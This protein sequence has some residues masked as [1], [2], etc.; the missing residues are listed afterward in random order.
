MQPDQ[1]LDWL[2]FGLTPGLGPRM[3]GKLLQDFGSPEAI[4]SASLTA[5]E[6]ERLPTAAAQAIRTRQSLSA[7]SKELAQVQALGFRRVTRDEPN[8][9]QRLREIYDPPPSLVCPRKC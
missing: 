7:A 8:Y 4:F 1:Y 6:S 2:A 9:P 5:L 3:A